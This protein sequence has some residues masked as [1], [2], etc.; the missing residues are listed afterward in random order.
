MK[1]DRPYKPRN[2]NEQ[3]LK[4][5]HDAIQEA[6]DE[7]EQPDSPEGFCYAMK[8][9]FNIKARIAARLGIINDPA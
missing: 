4:S 9:L 5:C 8:G 1:T 7:W 2:E 6:F 3:L